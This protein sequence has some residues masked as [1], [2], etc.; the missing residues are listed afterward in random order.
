MAASAF[1][2]LSA[3]TELFVTAAVYTVIWQ[4]YHHDR[5]RGGLLSFALTY[6]VLVNVAYMT[7]RLVSDGGGSDRPEWLSLL[8]AGHGLLSLVMLVGLIWFGL[9]AFRAHRRGRNLFREQKS[10]TVAFVVLWA[11]SILSGEAIYLAEY[12]F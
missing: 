9:A 3:V 10:A 11:V 7:F 12:V 4:A 6:E 1:S 8:Y 2:T 5:F